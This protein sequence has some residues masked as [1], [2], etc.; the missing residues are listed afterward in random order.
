MHAERS[1]PSN[2]WTLYFRLFFLV[3]ILLLNY[4]IPFNLYHHPLYNKNFKLLWQL[5]L[6][7]FH[8]KLWKENLF[9]VLSSQEFYFVSSSSLFSA[10]LYL[11]FHCIAMS[12]GFTSQCIYSI[13]VHTDTRFPVCGCEGVRKVREGD[14]SQKAADRLHFFA[15]LFRLAGLPVCLPAFAAR[16]AK[17][18]AT[19][20]CCV[21]VFLQKDS[22]CVHGSA[23]HIICALAL[24]KSNARI[25][26]PNL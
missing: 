12:V 7:T 19:I 5:Y 26:W 13:H 6:S 21:C 9:F 16:R 25:T 17:K 11:Y 1:L 10:K 22:L 4:V 18:F 15:S 23:F 14:G 8:P 2:R 3:T 20:L 24:E